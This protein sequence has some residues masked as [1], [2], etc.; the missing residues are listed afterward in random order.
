MLLQP[1]PHGIWQAVQVPWRPACRKSYMATMSRLPERDVAAHLLLCWQ[2]PCGDEWVIVRVDD[3]R[4]QLQGLQPGFGRCPAPI[5][6][7]IFEPVQGRGEYIVKVEEIARR[8][9]GFAT[10]EAWVLTQFDQG[11]GLHRVQK[12]RRIGELVEALPERL[13]AGCEINRRADRTYSVYHFCG[14]TSGFLRP[15][16]KSIAAQGDAHGQDRP[17]VL[18]LQTAQ[19]PVD[20]FIVSRVVGPGCEIDFPTAASKVRHDIA[21]SL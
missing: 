10:E 2:T 9:Q 21:P 11:L 15:A 3:Q 19:Y 20:F 14:G 17:P 4:G 6:L 12:H 1:L 18:G 8:L 7:R 16:Q 13:S 5:V